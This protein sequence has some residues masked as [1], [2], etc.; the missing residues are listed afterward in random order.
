MLVASV[1][2]PKPEHQEQKFFALAEPKLE[3][4]LEILKS[5]WGLGTK[6]E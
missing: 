6:E 4:K 3:P 1:V 5:L 2:V